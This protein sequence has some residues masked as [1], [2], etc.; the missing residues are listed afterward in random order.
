MTAKTVRARR[1]PVRAEEQV[2][3]ASPPSLKS[4]LINAATS[5][6][7]KAA[8][9]VIGTV[10]LAALAGAIIGPKRIEREVIRPVRG[11]VEH[12]AERLWE[13]A[14]PLRDQIAGLFQSAG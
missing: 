10:G 14:R 11:R 9:I 2:H 13:E 8:Y 7:A 1:Q 5:P 6:Q 3:R 12:E 4:Q